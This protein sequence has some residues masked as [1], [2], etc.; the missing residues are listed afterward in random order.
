MA[1]LLH[2]FVEVYANSSTIS[3]HAFPSAY[4]FKRRKHLT[5]EFFLCLVLGQEQ[6]TRLPLRLNACSGVMVDMWKPGRSL[7]H[8]GHSTSS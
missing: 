1:F 4:T 8:H 5:A 7:E 3:F 2:S 6:Q